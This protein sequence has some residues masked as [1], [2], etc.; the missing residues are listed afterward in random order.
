MNKKS[1]VGCGGGG[2]IDGHG[3]GDIRPNSKTFNRYISYIANEA[4]LF[5]FNKIILSIIGDCIKNII[6]SG[7][8]A[9]LQ[10]VHGCRKLCYIIVIIILL[11]IVILFHIYM[12]A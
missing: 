10:Q 9:V 6:T 4:W 2:N 1:D 8:R 7:S 12:Y 5:F 3:D 11:I